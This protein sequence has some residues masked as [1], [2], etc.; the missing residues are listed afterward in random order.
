[1]LLT[2]KNKENKDA[3]QRTR[4]QKTR[5]NDTH[6]RRKRRKTKH[7][8]TNTILPF[9]KRILPNRKKNNNTRRI[10]NF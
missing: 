6:N 4:I 2:K 7:R 10:K 8:H 1:M 5:S 3:Q 9:S